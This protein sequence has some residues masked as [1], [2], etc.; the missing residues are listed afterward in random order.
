MMI[1][2][3][4]ACVLACG[5]AAPSVPLSAVA[6][7]KTSEVQK[8]DAAAL[9]RKADKLF[10]AYARS[11]YRLPMEQAPHSAIGVSAGY[12]EA[13][14]SGDRRSC[15]LAME[16][17]P[18]MHGYPSRS[19]RELALKMVRRNCRAGDQMSCRALP[20]DESKVPD[21]ELPGWAGR[22][23]TCSKPPCTEVLRQECAEGFPMSCRRLFEL[24][25]PE[26][27]MRAAS[28]AIK[29]CRAGI[30]NDCR[31]IYGLSPTPADHEFATAQFCTL[32]GHCMFHVDDDQDP[33]LEVREELERTCQY[34]PGFDGEVA[35]DLLVIGYHE[36]RYPEPVPGRARALAAWKCRDAAPDSYCV[37]DMRKMFPDSAAPSG[38][39]AP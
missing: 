10:A 27:R 1:S 36:G 26:E 15:W 4:L 21:R 22:A 35:C 13:C 34:V 30:L 14:Q 19:G 6:A 37:Q 8:T 18:A 9:V 39:A 28:I 25:G 23:R 16:I 20:K 5:T 29:G 7:Q 2:A 3:L 38:T 11:D 32:T 12:L 24:A 31:A 17:H 33:P